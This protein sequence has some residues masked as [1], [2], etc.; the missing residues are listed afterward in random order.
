MDSNGRLDAGHF[1]VLIERSFGWSLNRVTPSDSFA[2]T[3]AAW[4]SRDG[5]DCAH[6]R[7][8]T[9]QYIIRSMAARDEWQDC[10][11]SNKAASCART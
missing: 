1:Y 5:F 6:A 2:W 8:A 7:V 11:L 3:G 4:S 10:W 9:L